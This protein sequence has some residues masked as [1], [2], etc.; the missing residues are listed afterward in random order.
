MM[1][2]QGTIQLENSVMYCYC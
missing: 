2:Y 1:I